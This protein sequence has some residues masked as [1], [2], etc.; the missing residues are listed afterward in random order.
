M[1]MSQSSTVSIVRCKD[2]ENFEFVKEQVRKAVGLIGGFESIISPGDKVLIKPNL[3]ADYEYHTGVTTNPNIIFAVSELCKEIGVK[4][5][6]IAEGAAIGNDT[7]EVFDKLGIRDLCEKYECKLVDLTKDQFSY[8]FNPMAKNMKRIR[9][10]KTFVE[11]DVVI[12]IPVM[13]THDALTVTLGLKNMKGVVH[14]ADKKRFH[15]WGLAQ[16]IADLGYLVMPEITIMDGTVALEGMGPVV[17]KPVN[18]GLILASIDT[19]ALD[20][21]CMEIMDFTIDE[22]DY[23]KISGE[24]GLGC[25]DLEKIKIAG[26]KINDVKRKFDRLTLDYE[27]LDRMGIKI[28]ACDACSG[29]SHAINSYVNDLS[30]KGKL[31]KIKDCTLIFGQ[32]PYIPEDSKNKIIRLG[33]CSKKLE[34]GLYVPGCP[35]H[36]LHISDFIEGKGFE[37]S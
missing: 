4:H 26:E 5:I 7:D 17:G 34:K 14:V 29:C 35:P 9:L 2:F 20:R 30:V 27:K 28:I 25:I 6:T 1:K 19:V 33:I 13:K 36:P 24:Q 32:N 21:V 15:K 12:N 22:V 8:F 16:N 37:K 18:L 31:D 3:L 11:S 23:I 10:P